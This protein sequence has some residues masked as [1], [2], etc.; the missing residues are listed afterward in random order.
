MDRAQA[1]ALL[2]RHTQTDSLRKHALGVEAAMRVYAEKFGEDI[3]T[4]GIVGLL[5]DFDYEETP[6]PKDHPMRGAGILEGEGCPAHIIYAIKSHATYL[7][8]ARLS[9]MDKTLFAVDELVGFVTAV[10]L[11]RPNR[12]VMEVSVDSVKKKMKQVGFAR[13]VSR[14]D[15]VQGAESL[16]IPLDEHIATVI[17]AM[18]GIADRLGLAGTS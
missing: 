7:G 13:A 4:Y 18:Q 1:L 9:R 16:G 14:E 5:H 17:V 6:D 15:I 12:S 8:L 2:Y 11:I 3:E 10:T